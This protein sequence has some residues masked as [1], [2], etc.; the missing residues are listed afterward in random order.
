MMLETDGEVIATSAIQQMI[1]SRRIVRFAA[2]NGHL[3]VSYGCPLSAIALVRPHCG[4]DLLLDGG[5]VERGRS[6][7]GR[8][9]DDGSCQAGDPLLYLHETPTFT[10]EERAGLHAQ[11]FRVF[12]FCDNG[13]ARAYTDA[14]DKAASARNV[15]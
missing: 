9:L 12:S 8:K 11:P 7:H 10:P 6:L 15:G 5:E 4:V 14:L 3:A 13:F 1:W 2:D